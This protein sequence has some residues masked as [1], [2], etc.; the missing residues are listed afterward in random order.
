ML[1][2]IQYEKIWEM[3]KKA[4]ASFWHASEVQLTQDVHDEITTNT[5]RLVE[6]MRAIAARHG[7]PFTASHAGSMWG[8][9][10]RDGRVRTFEDAKGSDSALFKRFFHAARRRGVSLAPSPYEAAFM[11]SAHGPAEIEETLDRLDGALGAAL[12]GRD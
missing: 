8:F 3:Y 5:S 7:T 1:F 2:P 12:S 10:F 6:G 9:F 4:E 11:S